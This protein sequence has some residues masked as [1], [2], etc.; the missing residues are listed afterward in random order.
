MDEYG[1]ALVCMDGRIQRKVADY[2]SASFG[3]RNIDTITTA[4]LVRYV[5]ENTNQTRAILD[6][7]EISVAT[8]GSRNIAVVA[9]HDCAGNPVAAKVQKDQV[10]RAAIRLAELYPDASV[11]GLWLGEHWIVEKVHQA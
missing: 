4:G 1:T 10:S 8:H 9:H 11:I 3:V 5:A 7:V 6:N 2:L